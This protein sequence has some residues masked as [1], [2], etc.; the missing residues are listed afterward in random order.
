MVTPVRSTYTRDP[1]VARGM[2]RIRL[3]QGL[4]LR[5][6]AALLECDISR[7][8]RIERGERGTPDPGIVAGLLGVP[9]TYLLAPCPRCGYAPQAGY[10]CL[11]CG[12]STQ[13]DR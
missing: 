5:D 11:R 6:V 9:V 10:M 2:R 13:E 4:S 3:E 7:I 12:V 8:S 1:M